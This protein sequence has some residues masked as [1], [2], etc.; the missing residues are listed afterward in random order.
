MRVVH[1]VCLRA[2]ASSNVHVTLTK[3]NP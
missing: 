3:S 1:L 2:S